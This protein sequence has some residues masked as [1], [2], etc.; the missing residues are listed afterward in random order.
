MEGHEGR[1]ELPG[2]VDQVSQCSF[3]GRDAKGDWTL[4]ETSAER[5]LVCRSAT[6]GPS[7]ARTAPGRLDTTEPPDL[8]AA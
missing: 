7:G 2:I 1:R 6:P 4:D 8:G 5:R 3:F